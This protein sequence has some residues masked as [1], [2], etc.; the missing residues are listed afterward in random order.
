MNAKRNTVRLPTASEEQFAERVAL[1]ALASGN[2]S[3]R[4]LLDGL[5]DSLKSEAVGAFEAAQGA[6]P[7][8]RRGRLAQLLGARPDA[9][10]RLE[11][12]ARLASPELQSALRQAAPA[13]LRETVTSVRL[14][15]EVADT[16]R[17]FAGRLVREALG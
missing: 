14:D 1:F 16:V 12:T 15:G 9:D 3:A 17:A 7:V 10:T 8:A 5:A 6:D 11:R 13:Y 4:Q 2:A